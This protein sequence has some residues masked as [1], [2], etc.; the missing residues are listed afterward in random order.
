MRMRS[1]TYINVTF[2]YR[3]Q[4]IFKDSCRS[5]TALISSTLITSLGWCLLSLKEVTGFMFQEVHNNPAK[6]SSNEKE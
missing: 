6:N 5:L 4:L 2:I 3:K 1:D